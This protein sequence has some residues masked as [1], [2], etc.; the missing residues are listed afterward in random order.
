MIGEWA[1]GRQKYGHAAGVPRIT[2]APTANH[3]GPAVEDRS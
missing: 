3:T 2:P 1:S